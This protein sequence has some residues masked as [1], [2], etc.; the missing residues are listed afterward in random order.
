[1]KKTKKTLS[2]LEIKNA[3]MNDG[4]F[5]DLFPELKKDITAVINDPGCACNI[6]IY[7]KFFKY[8]KRLGE[9][10]SNRAIKTPE[11]ER[12][13]LEQNH[14]SVFNCKAD[15]LEGVLN[16]MHKIGRKQIAVA[17]YEDEI[18]IIVNDLGVVF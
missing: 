4:R 3:I 18:T 5:R 13:E 2:R 9:Y 15:E 6:P 10:F 14:W 7:D 11:D 12:R 16:K 8:K 17:R 1:M